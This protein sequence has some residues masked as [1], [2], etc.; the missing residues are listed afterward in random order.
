MAV[1]TQSKQQP[2][3]S[4]VTAS[5]WLCVLIQLLLLLYAFSVP[6]IKSS[7]VGVTPECSP[8]WVWACPYCLES[9]P[10]VPCYQPFCLAFFQSTFSPVCRVVSGF[11]CMLSTHRYTRSKFCGL[12]LA[13]SP[14]IWKD[15]P[16]VV[17]LITQQNHRLQS[18]ARFSLYALR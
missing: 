15:M 7:T 17:N 8:L 11:R 5:V 16:H 10:S 13:R 14:K 9:R 2:T 4:E 1:F 18:I 3:I 6:L 12:L